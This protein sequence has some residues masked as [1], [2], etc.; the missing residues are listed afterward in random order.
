MV[1]VNLIW[2]VGCDLIFRCGL[3]VIYFCFVSL[4]GIGCW[5]YYCG[6]VVVVCYFD[7][8]RVAGGHRWLLLWIVVW[9]VC[10][11]VLGGWF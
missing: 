1:S 6:F 3:V 9:V 4:L 2:R 7:L 11:V 5:C 8:L 10:A